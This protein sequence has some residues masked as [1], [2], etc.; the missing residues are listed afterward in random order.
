ML[1]M[2]MGYVYSWHKM[3]LLVKNIV[4]RHSKWYTTV[5]SVKCVVANQPLV[6]H[7]EMP[8]IGVVV[9]KGHCT[10]IIVTSSYVNPKQVYQTRL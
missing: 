9:N 7:V 1:F 8:T 2:G 6:F 10:L 3:M 5:T 4:V